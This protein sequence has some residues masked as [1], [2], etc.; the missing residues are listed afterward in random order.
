[1]NLDEL[2]TNV[3]VI[4]AAGKMGSGIA[5][6]VTQALANLKIK[7]PDKTYRLNLIDVNE[8]GLAGLQKYI[9]AQMT[10]VAE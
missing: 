4:G 5:A 10:K 1:M 7:N 6:L 8:Q 9:K 3:S 2:L